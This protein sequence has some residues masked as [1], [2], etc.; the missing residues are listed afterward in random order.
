MGRAFAVEIAQGTAKEVSDFW[1]GVII[2]PAPGRA[3]ASTK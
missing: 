2:V 3:R 1:R